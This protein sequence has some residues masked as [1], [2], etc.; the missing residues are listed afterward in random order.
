MAEP[1]DTFNNAV[2]RFNKGA[3]ANPDQTVAGPHWNVIESLLDINIIVKKVDDPTQVLTTK[4]TV[5]N[6]LRGMGGG[7]KPD[8][9]SFAAQ[10][11][12]STVT[13]LGAKSVTISGVGTYIDN[14]YAAAGSEAATPNKLAYCFILSQDASG[15]WLILN[16]WGAL[17]AA[18]GSI[19]DTSATY[20]SAT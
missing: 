9:P 16:V 14:T 18:D 13:N 2:D 11:P 10:Q 12:T 5:M 19:E 3:A 17:L 20:P 4:T 1:M 7:L 6:Y 8:K 15:K